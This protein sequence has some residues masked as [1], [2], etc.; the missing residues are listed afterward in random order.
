ME[1]EKMKN[2]GA[3]SAAILTA[4]LCISGTVFAAFM[5]C[6]SADLTGDCRV[7]LADFAVLALQWLDKSEPFLN[8]LAWV[9]INDSGAGMKDGS[10]NPISHGGFTG[11]MSKYEITNLQ[12]CDYLNAALASGDITV[13]G[14][15]VVGANGS[16]LGDDFVGEYY[17]NLAGPG[18]AFDDALH[19]GATRISWT[20]ATFIVYEDFMNHPVSYVSWYGAAA[21]A[22]YYGLRLPTQW[23]W[24]AAADYN[25][26]YTYG[27]GT[28]INNSIANYAGT[29]HFCGTTAVGYFGTYGYGLCDMAGNVWEWTDSIYSE[30]YRVIRS[31]SWRS[32]TYD[33]SVA[34]WHFYERNSAYDSIGFRVCR[35]AA[36][37]LYGMTWVS[38]Y[39]TGEGMKDTGDYPIFHG[40]FIGEMSQYETTNAQYAQ[41]LNAAKASGAITVSGNYVVGTSGPYSGQNYYNLAGAGYTYNGATNGGAARINW[42]GSLFTVDS[43]FENHPV[44]YVSWYG[45]TAFASYYGWRLPTEWEWQ[46]TADYYNGMYKTACGNYIT[47]SIA[48][49]YGSNHPDGT[50][51]VGA[52]GTYGYGMSDMAG[53]VSEWTST[54]SG[55]YRIHRDGCWSDLDAFCAVWARYYYHYTPPDVMDYNCG[56]R[57]CR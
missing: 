21:F 52:F 42:T 2:T 3:F 55:I 31:G 11:E 25:G 28:S 40:G 38:I 48:N 5:T 51:A 15:D 39:D 22:S 47:N 17:Y 7:D 37:G 41:Y 24:Q 27:C 56:F 29:Y 57:A 9:S 8:R 50:T 34:Y 43:G 35:S 36:P 23:E 26:S 18:V 1:N 44:T 19:G 4:V 49:Y 12:Y 16:N 54:V 20:G 14:T 45:A 32:D 46:A 30:I 10:G 53:N 6:P 33:C 13:S